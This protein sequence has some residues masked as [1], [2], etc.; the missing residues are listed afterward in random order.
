MKDIKNDISKCSIFKGIDV[1]DIEKIK[2]KVAYYKKGE[3]IAIEGAKCDSIGIIINGC[4]EIQKIYPN[5]KIIVMKKLKNYDTFGEAIVFSKETTYPSTLI[6]LSDTKIVFIKKNEIID[7]CFK[8]VRFLNNFM[9]MLSEKIIELNKKIK[10]SNLITVKQKVVNFI[11]EE[12]E[13]Q[14]SN[15]IN[16]NM[17]KK[18]LSEIL[19]VPRPSLSRELI[20]LRENNIINFNKDNIEILN[21]IELKEIMY[22]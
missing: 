13:K 10:D 20:F 7:L 2:Y 17:S 6:S 11:L 9:E 21:L 8:N 14:M 19:G 4:S 16:I 5:G 18:E 15:K 3:T 1:T 12:Y 22:K